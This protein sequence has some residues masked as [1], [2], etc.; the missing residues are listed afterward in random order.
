VLQIA[1]QD[2]VQLTDKYFT[3]GRSFTGVLSRLIWRSLGYLAHPACRLTY[4]T[5]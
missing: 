5:Q 4:L 1:V 2:I 3:P